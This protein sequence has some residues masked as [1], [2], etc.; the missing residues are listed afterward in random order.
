MDV[1]DEVQE[2]VER[3][4]F[5]S[6]AFVDDNFTA[7]PKRVIEICDE[8][9]SRKLDVTSWLQARADSIVR[10]PDMVEAMAASGVKT[11]F[12]GIESASDVILK[13]YGKQSTVETAQNAVDMLRKH[14]I[15]AW[16]SFIIGGLNETRD[17]V[18]STIKFA[19]KLRPAVVQFSI[20]TPYPG[21]RL[22]EEAGDRIFTRDWNLYD[23]AHSVMKIDHIEP[24]DLEALLFKAYRSFYLRPRQLIQMLADRLKEGINLKAM[25]HDVRWLR[26]IRAAMLG[27]RYRASTA[28]KP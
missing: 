13:D 21:C 16:G 9:I 3:Y 26:D 28:A 10:Y 23:G 18:L 12:L 17:M 14:G 4:G 11:V 25:V 8:M 27:D 6:I 24:R 15:R 5:G 1:V 20:L 2:V 19:K 22:Y 7:N